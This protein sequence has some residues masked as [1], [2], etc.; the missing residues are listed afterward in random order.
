LIIL[1]IFGEEYKLRSSSYAVFSNLLTLHPSFHLNSLPYT[2]GL[3]KR[4]H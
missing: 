2:L 3:C 1:I 4:Y